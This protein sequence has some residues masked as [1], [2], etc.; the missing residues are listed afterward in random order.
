CVR[1]FVS[2]WLCDGLSRVQG[3]SPKESWDR[4]QQ[5]PV[6]L[7]RNKQYYGHIKSNG[8][9]NDAAP[10]AYFPFHC[11]SI[12]VVNMKMAWEEALE[13][14]RK[15]QSDLPSLLSETELLQAQNA[16]QKADISD[17]VW[18]GLRYLSDHWLWVK[19]DPLVY[20]NW[21]QGDQDHQCPFYVC[22]VSNGKW[23]DL[24]SKTSF[25]FYCINISCRCFNILGIL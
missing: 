4:L 15:N 23:N 10:G 1:L 20:E 22:L 6:T 13:H 25:P 24:S 8:K 16:V 5:I 21:P 19:G 11:I 9:W 14:C 2:M 3:L 12:N 17:P 18:I 7:V